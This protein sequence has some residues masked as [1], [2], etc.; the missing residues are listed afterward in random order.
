MKIDGPSRNFVDRNSPLYQ[1]L[2]AAHQR[3]MQ[4]DAST[5]GEQAAAEA[6][7]RLNWVDL[8]L[9]SRALLPELAALSKKFSAHTRLVLCGMGGSS[10]GRL[11]QR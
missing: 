7:I 10:L 1:S 6:A 5:W 11:N 4:K 9:T 2:I 8:P 3:I